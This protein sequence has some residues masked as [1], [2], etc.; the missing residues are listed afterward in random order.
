MSACKEAGC[1]KAACRAFTAM[2]SQR[3]R[4]LEDSDTLLRALA[5][6][7]PTARLLASLTCTAAVIAELGARLRA[8]FP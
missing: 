3:R 6:A 2:R 7:A 1:I 5:L 4:V 8:M